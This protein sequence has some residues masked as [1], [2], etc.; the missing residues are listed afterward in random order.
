MIENLGYIKIDSIQPEMKQNLL[1]KM[2]GEMPKEKRGLLLLEKIVFRKYDDF[3]NIV[4]AT[5]KRDKDSLEKMKKTMQKV[6]FRLTDKQIDF[7]ELY[8]KSGN[9]DEVENKNEKRALTRL[10]IVFDNKQG[11]L[12][13][14]VDITKDRFGRN[15][16]HYSAK[17][18]FGKRM[19]R[20]IE[21]T[22]ATFFER[23]KRG[24]K[25][26]GIEQD[27]FT[28]MEKHQKEIEKGE[29]NEIS[30]DL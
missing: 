15:Q 13:T 1:D 4:L 5:I 12:A 9:L 11:I 26:R 24:V 29:E 16:I 18:P 19:E 27:A 23:L 30:S 3:K 10:A 14:K 21:D 28:Q 17:E 2:R 20:S 25:T 6:T 22:K 7:E 8:K